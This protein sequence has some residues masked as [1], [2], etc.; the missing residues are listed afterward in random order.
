VAATAAIAKRPKIFFSFLYI[1]ARNALY[2]KNGCIASIQ[3]KYK[4]PDLVGQIVLFFAKL[5]NRALTGQLRA[6]E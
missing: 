4:R 3:E 6:L 1:Y 2:F 5:Q